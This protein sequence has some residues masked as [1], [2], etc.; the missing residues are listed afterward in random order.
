MNLTLKRS[1][2]NPKATI[3]SLEVDGEFECWILEN[4]IYQIPAG[5]YSVQITFSQRFQKPLPLIEGIPGRSGIRIHPG[6]SPGDSL[7]CLLPGTSHDA[8]HVWNSRLAFNLL[9]KRLKEALDSGATVR[10]TIAD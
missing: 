10:L 6:N 8:E 2:T 9:F 1:L 3:G 5:S 4:P 7:G